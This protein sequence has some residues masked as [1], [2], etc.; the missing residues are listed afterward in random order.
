MTPEHVFIVIKNIY[1]LLFTVIYC[2]SH[3]AR[4]VGRKWAIV[5]SIVAQSLGSVN[6]MTGVIGWLVTVSLTAI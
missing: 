1:L 6:N 3:T 2:Y 5:I 4:K